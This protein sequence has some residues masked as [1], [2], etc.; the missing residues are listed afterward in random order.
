MSVRAA[1]L[2]LPHSV[3]FR[4]RNTSF[5]VPVGL[6]SKICGLLKQ[7]LYVAWPNI[8]AIT[9]ANIYWAFARMC[10]VLYIQDLA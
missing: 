7:E 3:F 9:V 10:Q 6:W 1:D 2:A 4:K 5:W 8:I